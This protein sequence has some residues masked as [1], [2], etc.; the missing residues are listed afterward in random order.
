M[1]LVD[2]GAERVNIF[3]DEPFSSRFYSGIHRAFIAAYNNVFTFPEILP[4][5]HI[6]V[7][8][9][10]ICSR[11]NLPVWELEFACSPY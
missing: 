5:G 10:N 6:T 7:M 1:W 3:T 11:K 8:A 4:A 2:Q 9:T